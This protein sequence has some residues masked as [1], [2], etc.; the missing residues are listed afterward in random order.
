MGLTPRGKEK[1]PYEILPNVEIIKVAC[2]NSHM[3]FLSIHG[4]VF[5]AGCA[6]QG[7]LGRVTG[8][9]AD[10]NARSSNNGQL[11]KLLQPSPISLKP[12]LKLH[13]DNIWSGGFGTYAKVAGKKHIYVFGLNN[14]NQLGKFEE[15][16]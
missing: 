14:Y 11:A 10:R 13:F 9:S 16:C 7:Q 6:E 5:T 8:R 1:H 15:I 4:E 12:S 3:V 2:G